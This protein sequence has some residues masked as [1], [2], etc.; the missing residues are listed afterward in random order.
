MTDNQ[1]KQQEKEQEQRDQSNP[2]KVEASIRAQTAMFYAQYLKMNKNDIRYKAAKTLFGTGDN[3]YEWA[4]SMINKVLNPVS[5]DVMVE[6]KKRNDTEQCYI[7]QETSDLL[8]VL[9][10]V[11]ITIV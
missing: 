8:R 7:N 6:V 3:V 2:S 11:S 9:T 10:G 1:N 4:M 5:Q